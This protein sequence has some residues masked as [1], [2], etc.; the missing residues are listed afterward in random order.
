MD[1]PVTRNEFDRFARA[2]DPGVL[3]GSIEDTQRTVLF[4]PE[5]EGGAVGLEDG[6]LRVARASLVAAVQPSLM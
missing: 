2:K 6:R 4:G 3:T 5:R 1:L